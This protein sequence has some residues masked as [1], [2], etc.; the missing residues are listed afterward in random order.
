MD[1]YVAGFDKINYHSNHNNLKLLDSK[2]FPKDPE[3][4]AIFTDESISFISNSKT[5][6]QPKDESQCRIH[7]KPLE[8]FCFE[9]QKLFCLNCI[10]EKQH[11]GYDIHDIDSS[12][13]KMREKILNKISH[14]NSEGNSQYFLLFQRITQKLKS[15][16]ENSVFSISK[17]DMI[18][19]ELQNLI[20]NKKQELINNLK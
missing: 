2:T 18:F 6:K 3:F 10:I 14:I 13:S 15:L 11:Q 16:K 19:D 4:S 7:K 17:V 9:N 8:A 1:L 5:T 20:I 12:L